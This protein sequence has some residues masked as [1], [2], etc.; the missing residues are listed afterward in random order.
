MHHT[1]VALSGSFLEQKVSSFMY[2]WQFFTW[3]KIYSSRAS[4]TSLRYA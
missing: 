1:K 3:L 4:I 2:P